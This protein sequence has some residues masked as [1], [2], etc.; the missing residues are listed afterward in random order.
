VSDVSD[1]ME[2]GKFKGQPLREVP[3]RYLEWLIATYEQHLRTWRAEIKRRVAE[4]E[5]TNKDVGGREAMKRVDSADL[6]PWEGP[7][8]FAAIRVH[9]RRAKVYQAARI[10]TRRQRELGS[11]AGQRR[12]RQV[13]RQV[14][15]NVQ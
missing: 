6:P 15:G 4:S 7:D 2:F 1:V 13:W 12:R 14:R 9:P 5:P 10:K 3:Q 8:E 11:R